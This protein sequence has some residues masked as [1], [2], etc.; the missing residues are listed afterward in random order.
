LG[1]F[2][3]MPAFLATA[4][5]KVILFGEHAVVYGQP[6]I[7][8]PVMQVQA[9]AIVIAE[10]KSPRGMVRVIAPDVGLETTLD[11]LPQDHPFAVVISKAAAALGVSNIPACSIQINST[12]PIAGGMGSGAAVS[13]AI[14]RALSASWGHPLS[15]TQI[16]ELVYQSEQIYHGT[17]SGIDNTV[18]TY[19]RPVYFVKDKDVEI[20]SVKHP[21]TLVIGDSGIK[22]PTAQAVGAVRHAWQQDPQQYEQLFKAVGVIT[23][24]ARKA[25]RSGKVEVLGSL[26]NENH[27]L[28]QQ[29]GIS[30][31][32][33][34]TLVEAARAAG[35]FGAKLS[36]AG[37][38]GSMI[39]LVREGLSNTV[40][41]ALIS[42][43]A[44]GTIVTEV[45]KT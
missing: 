11:S 4:P 18:I 20:L 19:A 8:V 2:K 16:S 28:L 10:P 45:G 15:D 25:I 29:M 26:M 17:P 21:F 43:G 6:A 3:A 42:A 30:S 9:K 32:E 40:T 23:T 22:S 34:D 33:L 35:A 37:R 12:I 5:G 36:G 39:A 44:V 27:A 14:L 41:T 38:G 31:P 13:V 7:A 24:S 1:N